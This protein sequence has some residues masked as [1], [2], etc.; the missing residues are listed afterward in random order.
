MHVLL[1][2]DSTT[3]RARIAA[4]LRELDDLTVHEAAAAAEALE[5]VKRHVY[6]VVV[7]DLH[8]PG[9][10]GLELL[11][12]L[13]SAAPGALLI[14]LSNETSEHHRR[15]C[16]ARGATSFLDKSR[17]FSHLPAVIRLLGAARGS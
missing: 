11:S 15:E 7:V 3:V 6:G 10:S 5:L 14:V 13:K 16:L 1:V 4:M 8:M 9:R 2:D 12:E 17:E